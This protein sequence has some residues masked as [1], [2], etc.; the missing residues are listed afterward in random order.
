MQIKRGSAG[1]SSV[2]APTLR[3]PRRAASTAALRSSTSEDA[4]ATSLQMFFLLLSLQRRSQH[5]HSEEVRREMSWFAVCTESISLNSAATQCTASAVAATWFISVSLLCYR[6]WAHER[7]NDEDIGSPAL[8]IRGTYDRR[9]RWL[10]RLISSPFVRAL[11]GD[12]VPRHS[13]FVWF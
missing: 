3:P 4:D 7:R 11:R 5:T 12:T 6:P 8:Y 10:R 2:V 1:P 13:V 9:R